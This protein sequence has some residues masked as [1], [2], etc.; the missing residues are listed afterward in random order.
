[1]PYCHAE[2]HNVECHH[3]ECHHAERHY[4]ECHFEESHMLS[5]ILMSV[6]MLSVLLMSVVMLSAILMSVSWRQFVRQIFIGNITTV[7]GLCCK[8]FIGR[9]CCRIVISKSVF[10]TF[11]LV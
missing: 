7:W 10:I 6:I 9:N 8:T 11:L 3:A 2:H 4:A 5:I 1:M